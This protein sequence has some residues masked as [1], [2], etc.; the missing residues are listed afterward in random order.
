MTSETL[1]DAIAT[2]IKDVA[3]IKAWVAA[4]FSGETNITVYE[5]FDPDNMPGETNTPAIFIWEPGRGIITFSRGDRFEI[6]R[7]IHIA[8]WVQQTATTTS[9]NVVKQDGVFDA[10]RLLELVWKEIE[11]SCAWPVNTGVT[12]TRKRVSFENMTIGDLS[13]QHPHYIRRGDFTFT[14][15]EAYNA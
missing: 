3:A 11:N 4:T 9:G 12:D 6:T 10:D 8:A 15:E 5:G 13:A 1:L 2:A 14:Y 7:T